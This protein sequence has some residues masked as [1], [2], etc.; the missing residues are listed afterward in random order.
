M[1]VSAI[2]QSDP[3][4]YTYS[5][6]LVLSSM[7]VQSERLDR[8]PCAVR[9]EVVLFLNLLYP[10]EPCLCTHVYACVSRSAHCRR[11]GLLGTGSDGFPDPQRTRQPG[12]TP[13]QGHV[14]GDSGFGDVAG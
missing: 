6:F 3:C 2:Q 4:M 11:M 12:Q 7:T 14:S 5:P 1:P 9:E 13:P 10:V 8:I